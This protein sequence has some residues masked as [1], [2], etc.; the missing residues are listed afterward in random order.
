MEELTFTLMAISG[1]LLL[2]AM[3]PGES[4]LLVARTTVATSRINGIAT[5]LSMGTG[6]FIFALVTMFGLQVIIKTMPDIYLFIR[7]LGGGYLIYLAYKFAFNNKSMATDN[8][9][10]EQESFSQS[11]L[12]GLIIQLSNPNTAL[13]FAS[14]FS[15][16][17]SH[18]LP[19]KMYIILPVIAFSIDAL[20]Y[21]FVAIALSYPKPR[22][23]YLRYKFFFDKIA[24]VL[25]LYLGVK[26]LFI[27]LS[28]FNIA[29]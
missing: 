17:L 13:V 9:A 20:W 16:L 18:A 19:F 12:Q 4:F 26:T 14:V 27:A 3:N 6:S 29:N 22:K 10:K 11:Y 28:Q 7:V 25:M 1:T 8:A 5:A 2:G 23:T 24:G 21:I 15:V